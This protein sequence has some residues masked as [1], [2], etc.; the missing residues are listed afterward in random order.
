MKDAKFTP[1]QHI[2]ECIVRKCV[3][4]A[5]SRYKLVIEEMEQVKYVVPK[6]LKAFVDAG[7]AVGISRAVQRERQKKEIRK[8]LLESFW[9]R[10]RDWLNGNFEEFR[11]GSDPEVDAF[12]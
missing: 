10:K 6:S 4:E 5:D 11:V 8:Q 7:G 1:P 2:Y 9:T 3:E 12:R